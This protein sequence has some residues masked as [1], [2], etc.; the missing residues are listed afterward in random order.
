MTKDNIG[1]KRR[2]AT[3]GENVCNAYP[4]QNDAC[5]E[6]VKNFYKSINGKM[7]KRYKDSKYRLRI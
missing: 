3:G 1:K 7:G 2:S 5:P 4:W 6:Y